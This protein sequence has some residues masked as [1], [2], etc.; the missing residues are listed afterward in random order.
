MRRGEIFNLKWEH[1]DFSEK[2]ILVKHTKSGKTREIPI[3]DRLYQ[4]LIGLSR[5]KGNS[6]YVFPNPDTGRPYIDVKKSFKFSCK[7]AGISDLRFHDLRHTFASRLVKAGV[8]LITVRDLLGHFSVR[9]TQRYTHSCM[10]QKKRAI[11]LLHRVSSETSKKRED[12]L[13]KCY[14]N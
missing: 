10:D 12:L 8:D 14:V 6:E 1:I 9:V 11:E 4:L 7:K 5:S 13:H 2:I 3:S